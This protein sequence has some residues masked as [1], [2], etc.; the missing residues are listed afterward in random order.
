M[1]SCYQRSRAGENGV[2]YFLKVLAMAL[3]SAGNHAKKAFVLRLVEGS[4]SWL[5]TINL[6]K[7]AH[8]FHAC[9]RIRHDPRTSPMDTERARAVR[10]LC[11]RH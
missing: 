6:P 3:I 11:S 4:V 2:D 8:E 7:V 10:A 1:P 5:A 9:S